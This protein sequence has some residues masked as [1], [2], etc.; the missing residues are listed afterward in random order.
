MPWALVLDVG[1]CEVRMNEFVRRMLV[2]CAA[3]VVAAIGAGIGEALSD[4]ILD[5]WDPLDK[6]K[7]R[8][9]SKKKLRFC[10][11]RQRRKG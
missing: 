1:R 2:T 4:E 3:S 7:K 10:S 11:L 9:S 6:R 5:R 8:K